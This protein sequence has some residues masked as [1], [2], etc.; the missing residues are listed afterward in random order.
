MLHASTDAHVCVFCRSICD[1]SSYSQGMCTIRLAACLS[2]LACMRAC[3][4]RLVGSPCRPSTIISLC[5]AFTNASH[6][7]CVCRCPPG[8]RSS[9]TPSS[10]T[11][12]VAVDS[13]S[14]WQALWLLRHAFESSSLVMSVR[15]SSRL[16]CVC[17]LC[18]F[19]Q[20]HSCRP[21]VRLSFSITCVYRHRIRK[22]QTALFFLR[23]AVSSPC[24]VAALHPARSCGRLKLVSG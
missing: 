17:G 14:K 24:R 3:E 18:S 5:A 13:C 11:S 12:F 23:V 19:I 10:S 15:H 20:A 1:R 6:L 7:N 9:D 16:K 8:G 4:I 2:C 21:L 22:R